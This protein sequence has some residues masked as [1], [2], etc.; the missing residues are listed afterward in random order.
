MQLPRKPRTTARGENN[1]QYAVLTTK[2]PRLVELI[3]EVFGC[4]HGSL[5]QPLSSFFR[6]PVSNCT[7][8][9]TQARQQLPAVPN[10]KAPLSLGK[11]AACSQHLTSRIA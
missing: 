1:V 3:L 4:G 10:A 2:P 5:S 11:A 6:H 7:Q 9:G 8:C